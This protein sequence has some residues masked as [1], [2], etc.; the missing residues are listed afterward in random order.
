[1]SSDQMS[2]L[3]HSG[4]MVYAHVYCGDH[5]TEYLFQN[6]PENIANFI[7]SRP[8]ADQII[9]TDEMDRLI[10]GTIGYFIDKC[11]D[12]DLLAEIKRTLIPIQTGQ[13]EVQPFF[14]PTVDEV[15]GYCEKMDA[16]D[17]GYDEMPGT[18]L[19]ELQI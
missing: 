18:F 9:L 5:K 2:E 6:T 12:Q 1:M 17:E 13:E 19:N 10:L 14:C 7:G 11:P 15:G 4:S 8:T 16:L 3:L